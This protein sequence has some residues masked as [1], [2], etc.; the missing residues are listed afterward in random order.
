LNCTNAIHEISNYIDGELE[1]T[2]RIQLEEHFREC[3]G[4]A[5]IVRQTEVTIR[6]F[7][8]HQPADM[9]KDVRSRLHESLKRKLHNSK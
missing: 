5:T 8:S 7:S 2:V 1:A 6:I 3:E 4:C 9:P